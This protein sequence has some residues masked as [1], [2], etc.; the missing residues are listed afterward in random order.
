MSRASATTA[1]LVALTM[2]ASVSSAGVRVFSSEQVLGP[3][4]LNGEGLQ[5]MPGGVI[6]LEFEEAV[7]ILGYSTKIVDDEGSELGRDLQCHSMMVSPLDESWKGS[8][9]NGTPFEGFFSDGFTPKLILPQGFGVFLDDGESLE[10]SPMFN[11]R[12]PD[13]VSASMKVTVDFVRQRDLTEPLRP[14]FATVGTVTDP[15]LYMVPPG[16]D[17]RE[18]QYRFPYAGV[19]H[20]MGVHIHPYGRSFELINLTRGET[21]WLADGTHGEDGRLTEMPFYSSATGYS[22]TPED[23]FLLR[24][25][26]YN[27]TDVEQDAMAG[28]FFFFS[29][30]DDKLPQRPETSV[31]D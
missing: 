28:L 12:S 11:N 7:W 19:I 10:L 23:R 16:E 4:S 8:A 20:A 5:Q 15:F 13:P 21:V 30:I 1:V 25:T 9:H 22:F 3:Y 27:P 18:R 31:L 26:Y 29:T 14:L 17:V 24:A 6:P 2:S